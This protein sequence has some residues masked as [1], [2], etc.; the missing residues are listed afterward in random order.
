MK[1]YKTPWLARVLFPSLTWRVSTSDKTIFLTFDDGPN[2]GITDWVL[3]VLDD[4][5]AKA[6]FF[7]VGENVKKCPELVSRILSEDHSIGNHTMTHVN[8][9]K[10]SS[11]DYIQNIELCQQALDSFHQ[12]PLFRPPYGQ[13]THSMASRL[14]GD[15]QIIMWDV[16][17]YDF[18]QDLD[19][20]HK[21]HKCNK[22]S[23]PGSI[24]VFHDSEKAEDHLKYILPKYL[25]QMSDRGFQFKRLANGH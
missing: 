10:S 19:P 1:Y 4:F 11:H 20:D 15:Y 13:I 23:D 7:L 8:L 3:D 25:K 16:L 24:I 2:K 6:S 5:G 21:L 17:S 9:R 18:D 14:K 12:T 22:Y